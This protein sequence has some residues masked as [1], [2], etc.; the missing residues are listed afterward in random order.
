MLQ[1]LRQDF[2]GSNRHIGPGCF[3]QASLLYPADAFASVKFECRL[4]ESGTDS[5]S[6][7]DVQSGIPPY[8]PKTLCSDFLTKP[9]VASSC[10]GE[11]M[12][13][14]A[15]DQQVWGT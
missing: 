15:Y 1:D 12:A 5:P 10:K 13:L 9:F 11:T 7:Y 3:M 4:N 14:T 2:G 8:V 6:Q